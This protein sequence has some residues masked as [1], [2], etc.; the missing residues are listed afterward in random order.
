LVIPNWVWVR[1]VGYAKALELILFR[2]ILD[3]EMALSIGLLNLVVGHEELPVKAREWA[4]DLASLSPVAVCLELELFL[5]TQS[6][7]F[8]E[9]L[10]L[11]SALGALAVASDEA[12]E[13]LGRF[14]AK[15][16]EK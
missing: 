15:G 7:G 2:S 12:K 4:Q 5:R 13:L 10:A 9:G 16:K 1:I 14:V 6:K 11:E 3:A 8:D